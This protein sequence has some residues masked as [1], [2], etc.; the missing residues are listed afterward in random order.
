MKF[1][2]TDDRVLFGPSLEKIVQA[3]EEID[4]DTR[5]RIRLIN[6]SQDRLI[7]YIGHNYRVYLGSS[8]K[9]IYKLKILESI[10]YKIDEENLKVDYIDLSIVRKP[11][12]RLKK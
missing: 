12:I 8:D 4:I 11:V 9:V 2:Y 6:K 3:L 10:L 5:A 1:N 7:A